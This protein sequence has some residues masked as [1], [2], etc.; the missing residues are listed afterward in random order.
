M[1]GNPELAPERRRTTTL[2]IALQPIRDKDIRL[3]VDYLDTR[4]DNQA[5]S[6]GGATLPRLKAKT[7][8]ASPPCAKSLL[9]KSASKC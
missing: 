8:P 6:L 2:G 4:I 9:A 5:A 1:G 7:N 3:S